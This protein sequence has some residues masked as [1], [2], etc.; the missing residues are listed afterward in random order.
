MKK[1]SELFDPTKTRISFQNKLLVYLL[2]KCGG[3]FPSSLE[4]DKLLKQHAI[5]EQYVVRRHGT[6]RDALLAELLSEDLDQAIKKRRKGSFHQTE[7][8]CWPGGYFGYPGKSDHAKSLEDSLKARWRKEYLPGT[9]ALLA[10]SFCAGLAGMLKRLHPSAGR[11]RV[12]LHRVVVFGGEELLQQACDYLGLGIERGQPSAA[13]RTF[14]AE[15]ATIGLA[16]KSKLIVRSRMQVDPND[17]NQ[18]MQSLNLNDASRKMAS[19]VC[20]VLA[21]P[22]LHARA[23]GKNS[24]SDVLGVIYVDSTAKEFYVN[25]ESLKDIVAMAQSLLD[26]LL[27]LSRESLERIRNL[28][29]PAWR[30]QTVANFKMP[31]VNGTLELIRS[32]EP[33]KASHP[34]QLNFDHADFVPVQH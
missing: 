20:F 27:G 33:P 7:R 3:F 12:T 13:A 16:Y 15:N 28:P 32:I 17:L 11:L 19:E 21:M 1:L 10:T 23:S 25:D 30:S 29:S 6:E 18:A 5:E 2:Y 22:L 26:A 14:P 34:I 8:V 9:T 4:L 31:M 24:S